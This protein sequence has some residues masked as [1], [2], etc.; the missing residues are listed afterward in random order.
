MEW[1]E[2][3]VLYFSWKTD[4]ATR[5]SGMQLPMKEMAKECKYGQMAAYT[6]AT[7]RETRPMAKAD[8][9]MLMEM[10]TLVAGLMIKQK[11]M[12]FILI[13]MVLSIKETGKK[14]N[15]MVKVKRP[16]LMEHLTKEIM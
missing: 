8:S 12:V 14:I 5:D 4:H 9:F 15:N 11:A 3:G 2:N 13:Q 1:G 10:Y 16:G 7:G 6:K